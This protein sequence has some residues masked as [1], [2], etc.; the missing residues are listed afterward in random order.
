MTAPGFRL[1]SGPL[2]QG[3]LE[4]AIVQIGNSL[5]DLAEE[6]AAKS[7]AAAEAEVAYKLA[8][9]RTFLDLKAHGVLAANADGEPVRRRATEKEAEASATVEAED[10]YR[11]YKI[12]DA[13]SAATRD[14]SFVRRSRLESLRTL[15]ASARMA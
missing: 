7:N 11:A 2:S 5:E 9:Y 13:A 6:Y 14:A 3:E 1:P 4:E 12:T 10:L 15:A 8:Y